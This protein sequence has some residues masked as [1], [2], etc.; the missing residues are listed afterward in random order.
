MLVK[1]VKRVSQFRRNFPRG[2]LSRFC[3][4]KRDDQDNFVVPVE[5]V[6]FAE[7]M[8]HGKSQRLCFFSGPHSPRHS[9]AV[10]Y[11]GCLPDENSPCCGYCRCLPANVYSVSMRPFYP[12]P[13]T[14]VGVLS[15]I[16]NPLTCPVANPEFRV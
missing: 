13:T 10:F 16:C 12:Q 9:V 5:P 4:T 7:A 15:P 11:N 1:G 14:D 6:A 2:C 8:E 3:A